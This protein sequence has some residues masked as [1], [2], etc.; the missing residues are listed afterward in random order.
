M[1]KT[2]KK[3]EER[4]KRVKVVRKPHKI[5]FY[6]NKKSIYLSSMRKRGVWGRNFIYG[7]PS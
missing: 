3:I 4:I 7:A 6:L 1:K 5:K 2:V